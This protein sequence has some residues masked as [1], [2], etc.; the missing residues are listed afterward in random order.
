MADKAPHINPALLEQ[1]IL[2]LTSDEENKDIESYLSQHPEIAKEVKESQTMIEDFAMEYAMQPP[3]ALKGQVLEAVR[4]TPKSD[5]KV[6]KGITFNWLTGV[7][8]TLA[9]GFSILTFLLYQRQ[10]TMGQQI[11]QLTQQVGQLQQK[12]TLLASQKAEINQQFTVLKDVNT[13]HVHLRGSKLSP[14]ALIVVYWNEEDK[15]AY[16]NVVELPEIPKDKCLQLWADVDGEMVNMGV[17]KEDIDQLLKVPFVPNAESL[18]I[19]LEP[20]GGSER[21]D[22]SQIFAD[23]KMI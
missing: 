9:L 23:G 16:L 14:Q 5:L 13:S 2:G 21:P 22:V 11:A 12:N 10:S 17:L 7:A 20:K 19:T 3:D 8:A 6:A 4:T 1:Y 18:N 15:N